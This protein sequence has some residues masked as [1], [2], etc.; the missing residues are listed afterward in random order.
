[1][2]IVLSREEVCTAGRRSRS[3]VIE[4]K[5]GVSKDGLLLARQARLVFDTGGYADW[6]PGTTMIATLYAAGPYRIPHVLLEGYCVYT[7]RAG[8]TSFRAPGLPSTAFAFESHMDHIAQDLGIDPLEIRKR[9]TLRAGDFHP[10]AGRLEKS[11]AGA[12]LQAAADAIEW[13]EPTAS[14]H[15]GKG[16]ALSA[17][18][19]RGVPSSGVVKVNEDGTVAVLTGAVDLTGSNTIFAQI[20]AEELGIP[21]EDVT[22]MTGDT[23]AAPNAPLTGGSMIAYNMGGAVLR[24]AR[25]AKGQLFALAAELLG[26]DASALVAEDRMVYVKGDPG[27]GVSLAELSEA[28]QTSRG[29]YIVGK[30]SGPVLPPHEAF[31]AQ[32]AEVEVDPETGEVTVLRMVTA[33]DV[34]S[35]LNADTLEGQMEGAVSQGVGLGLFEEMLFDEGQVINP[36]FRDYLVPTAIDMPPVETVIV[37]DPSPHGPYGARGMGEAPAIPGAAAIANAVARSVGVRVLEP[38][39]TPEKIVRALRGW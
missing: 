37:E 30:G 38:P 6:G 15:C 3:A 17:W 29:G 35:A 18:H 14:R 36:S 12:V 23:D 2:H 33:Q 13:G 9:N 20:V 31:V 24:A 1:V 27:R 22:V 16:L 11:S 34:G 21:L 28:S 19:T 8:L 39:I 7:N 25:D 4:M 32:A 10:V 5:S 26:A